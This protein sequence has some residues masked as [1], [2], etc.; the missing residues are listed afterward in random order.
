MRRELAVMS[1]A[2]DANMA[3]PVPA[4]PGPRLWEGGIDASSRQLDSNRVRG[5]LSLRWLTTG[6]PAPVVVLHG[7]RPPNQALRLLKGKKEPTQTEGGRGG[8][9][10]PN[11]SLRSRPPISGLINFI[12]LFSEEHAAD[13]GG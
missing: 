13:V 2:T 12:L 1:G 8:R 11:K 3:S 4:V 7:P 10:R 6:L 5:C 9:Q